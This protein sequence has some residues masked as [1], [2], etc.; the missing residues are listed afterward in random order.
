MSN[1][2]RSREA[3]IAANQALLTGQFNGLHQRLETVLGRSPAPA[4]ADEVTRLR[5]AMPA[6]PA[7]ELLTR[8]FDLDPF[9]TDVVLLCTA[10]E[11]DG[12]IAAQIAELNGPDGRQ[13]LTLS[14]VFRAVPDAHWSAFA[15]GQPLRYWRLIELDGQGRFTAQ[16]LRLD[17][18]I[19]HFLLGVPALD[20]RVEPLLRRLSD[21]NIAPGRTLSLS[22]RIAEALDASDVVLLTGKDQ[23]V[24]GAALAAAAAHLDRRAA[25][26]E[27]ADLPSHPA[28]RN[29]LARLIARESRLSALVPAIGIEDA[30]DAA[31][32]GLPALLARL[33]APLAVL[34]RGPVPLGAVA[35]ARIEVTG[36]TAKERAQ[37]LREA[38]GPR[39]A[40]ASAI[41]AVA[42]HFDLTPTDLR[43][44]AQRVARRR[45]G[46]KPGATLW[47]AARQ[48]ARPRL[49]EL[50][51]RI[52]TRADWADLI[53]P[54]QREVTLREIATQVGHR[55]R[56]Y[57]EWGFAERL[58]SRGLGITALFAGA[59]GTGKTLA[60]EVIAHALDL[61]LYRIDLSAVVSKYIGETEKNLRRIFDAAETGGAV[62]LFDEADALFGKRSEV[63]DSHDRYANIEVSYLLQRMESYTGLAILTT[64]MKQNLDQA[65]LRRIRFVV[66]FPFPGL[67]ERTAIWARVMPAKVPRDGLEPR[68]LA[69]M[70]LPGGAIRNVALN[71]AFRA[72][73]DGNVVRPIHVLEAARSEYAKLEKPLTEA[74]LRGW[75]DAAERGAAA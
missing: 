19:L 65:F 49:E 2:Q 42:G 55:L 5:E 40:P 37:M 30:D 39:G 56:V 10:I 28:E 59:S 53:L 17:E 44:V 7:T 50:A 47:S 29:S 31:L 43:A 27:L 64:N 15:P 34:A 48:A 51:E 70:N 13:A 60:A 75:A 61:D 69:Q 32:R 16:T 66:D 57:D 74:E 4:A 22:E 41:A 38:L 36:L 18:R 58:S 3:W 72:A 12:R 52:E 20:P 62:L 24:T 9:M 33:E 71:A 63:K 46:E 14:A 11:L 54:Q 67:A 45:P 21:E 23:T 25:R 35:A 73:A 6:P 26:I 68:R 8:T 1:R